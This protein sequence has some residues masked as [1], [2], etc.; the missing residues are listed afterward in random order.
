MK[1]DI[2]SESLRQTAVRPDMQVANDDGAELDIRAILGKLWRGKWII[3]VSVLIAQSDLNH[4]R[5]LVDSEVVIERGRGRAV[6][7]PGAQPRT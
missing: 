2:P 7:A 4:A 5:S 1:Q 6:A 3:A